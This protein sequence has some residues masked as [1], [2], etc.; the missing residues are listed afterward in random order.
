MGTLVLSAA[1]TMVHANKNHRYSIRVGRSESPHGPFVDK[2]GKELTHGGGELIYGSNNDVYAPGG[3]GVLTEDTGD[4]L[5]YHYC[6]S[7]FFKNRLSGV[8]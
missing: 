2:Q 5:Y 3:P 4:I 6:G 7:L 1:S 8:S